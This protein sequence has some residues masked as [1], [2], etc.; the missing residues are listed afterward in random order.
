MTEKTSPDPLTF[1]RVLGHHPTGASV[2]T[3]MGLD[4]RPA[5]MVVGTFTSVSLDPPLVAFLPDKA[6]TSWPR[7]REAGSFCANVLSAGQEAVSRQ[8]ARSGGNK[9]RGIDWTPAPSGA[10]II[11]GAVAWVDCDIEQVFESGDH[12]IVIG[13]VRDLAVESTDVPLTFW[14]GRY[15]RIHPGRDEREPDEREPGERG[16]AAVPALAVG[17]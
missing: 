16:P 3:A 13:R 8:F 7:I 1:R 12:Y 11:A 5:G 2:V 15:T 6:S 4:G 14:Q 10:P 17:M 9:F